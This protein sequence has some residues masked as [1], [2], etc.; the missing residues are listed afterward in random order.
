MGAQGLSYLASV[1][2]FP[3][4]TPNPFVLVEFWQETDSGYF[5]FFFSFFAGNLS[6]LTAQKNGVSGGLGSG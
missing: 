1:T 4:I 3:P 2:W 6:I 5:F